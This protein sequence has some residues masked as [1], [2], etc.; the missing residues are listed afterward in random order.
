MAPTDLK[1]NL[2]GVVMM[3]MTELPIRTALTPAGIALLKILREG[4]IKEGLF[5]FRSCFLYDG[6]PT[7]PDLPLPDRSLPAGSVGTPC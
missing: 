7:G 4:R 5:D 3:S 6:V 2:E 1:T